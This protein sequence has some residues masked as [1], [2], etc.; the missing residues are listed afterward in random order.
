M[1]PPHPIW[2]PDRQFHGQL[3]ILCHFQSGYWGSYA[4]DIRPFWILC[5]GGSKKKKIADTS[6][7]N[8]QV[9]MAVKVLFT[10]HLLLSEHV[11]FCVKSCSF[12]HTIECY[13]LIF[14]LKC[15]SA[16]LHNFII[17]IFYLIP[18]NLDKSEALEVH[19]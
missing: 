3:L 15:S 19:L 10:S 4:I 18:M 1:E 11:I 2:S 8:I 6:R 16:I 13:I 5:Q 9:A 14:L 7:R 12:V 17:C